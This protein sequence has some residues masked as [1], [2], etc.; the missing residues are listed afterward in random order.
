MQHLWRAPILTVC[1]PRIIKWRGYEPKVDTVYVGRPNNALWRILRRRIRVTDNTYA[2]SLEP[3]NNR[4]RI[5]IRLCRFHLSTATATNRPPKNSM[6]A[7]C[8]YTLAY[9]RYSLST[10]FAFAVYT[11]TRKTKL[12]ST[13]ETL[14]S[15]SCDVLQRGHGSVFGSSNPHGHNHTVNRKKTPKCFRH[16]VF[17]KTPP[18][19]KKFGT[20]CTR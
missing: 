19:P 8:I 17:Y 1:G 20:H 2:G 11:L 18:I 9:K 15:F 4:T 7:F 13:V 12:Q 14:A 6:F 10:S 3:I 5:A 16:I